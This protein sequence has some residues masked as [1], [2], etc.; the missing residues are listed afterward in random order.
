M[1]IVE[2]SDP[3][4]NWWISGPAESLG[5]VQDLL[6]TPVPVT[7]VTWTICTVNREYCI[8][9]CH[10]VEIAKSRSS[11][12]SSIFPYLFFLIPEALVAT[13]PPNVLNSIESGSCPIVNP[14]S[15]NYK[16]QINF[17]T[18]LICWVVR[19]KELNHFF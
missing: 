9:K 3:K 2:P 15:F 5:T 14:F 12:I 13:Q 11:T 4:M 17:P 19:W 1:N 8:L 10:V 6:T 7:I 18:W 16:K